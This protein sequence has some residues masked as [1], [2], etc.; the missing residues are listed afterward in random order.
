LPSSS[1]RST[2]RIDANRSEAVNFSMRSEARPDSALDKSSKSLTS[3]VSSS[4]D[5]RM[6]RTCFTC[7]SLS[8]PSPCSSSSRD[9]PK[10]VWSG[11]RNSWLTFAT[12]RLFTS[13][14]RRSVSAFSASSACSE[15]TPRCD[16]SSWLYAVMSS[17]FLLASSFFCR[18][19]SRLSATTSSSDSLSCASVRL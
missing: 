6:K 2:P 8:R 16:S 13:A 18:P 17:S 1:G 15:R 5:E 4:A 14:A 7:S 11:V 10:I 9:K 3:A 19:I 12:T